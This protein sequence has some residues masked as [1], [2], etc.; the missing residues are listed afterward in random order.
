[1]LG[2]L[3]KRSEFIVPEDKEQVTPTITEDLKSIHLRNLFQRT[4]NPENLGVIRGLAGF[5]ERNFMMYGTIAK[6]L[7]IRGECIQILYDG[8]DLVIPKNLYE[9]KGESVDRNEWV[10]CINITAPTKT[11]Y[12]E[13]TGENLLHF[14]AMRSNAYPWKGETLYDGTTARLL[15]QVEDSLYKTAQLPAVQTIEANLTSKQQDELLSHFARGAPVI[16][17]PRNAHG[18]GAHPNQLRPQ[19]SKEMVELRDNLRANIL[20]QMGVPMSFLSAQGIASREGL[21][22]VEEGLLKPLR[23]AIYDEFNF[24]KVITEE[25]EFSNLFAGDIQG[26]A[27]AIKSLVDSGVALDKAMELTGLSE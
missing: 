22:Q 12:L 3:F 24:K 18:T 5:V 10:Y 9:V 2:R 23:Q 20:Q 13:R 15:A 6:E 8:Q 27:R 11:V 25:W 26:K 7:V 1:M 21:R 16:S 19:P 4:P 17:W 14:V